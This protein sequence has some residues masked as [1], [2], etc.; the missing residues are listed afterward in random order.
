MQTLNSLY[1]EEIG[2]DCYDNGNY[3]DQNGM[4]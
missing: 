4:H 2:S 3:L 1:L